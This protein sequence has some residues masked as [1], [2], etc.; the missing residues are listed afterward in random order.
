MEKLL[1]N[2]TILLLFF[3]GVFSF[4]VSFAK[5]IAGAS[6]DVY[7]VMGIGGGFWLLA[8]VITIYIR[9]AVKPV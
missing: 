4:V 7:G 5:A 8:A 3:G 2:V 9:K 6:P 1:L